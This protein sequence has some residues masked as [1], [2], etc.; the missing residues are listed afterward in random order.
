MSFLTA[1]L[2]VRQ[3]TKT[4]LET[5]FELESQGVTALFG[6]SGAG[7]TT[8]LKALAGL[9]PNQYTQGSVIHS[10]Y[11]SWQTEQFLLAPEKR[12]IGLVFQ[13]Q[14]LFPHLTIGE[15]LRYAQ[16]RQHDG[17][18]LTFDEI[19]TIFG[20]GSLLAR[21]PQALSGG[22]SQRAALARALIN[23]PRLLLMDEPLAALDWTART[24]ILNALNHIKSELQLP[25][26]YVSHQWDEVI[27]LADQVQMMDK[28][29]ITRSD[30]LAAL[31]TDIDFITQEQRLASAILMTQVSGH[32]PDEG[33]TEL[34]LGDQTILVPMITLN[35]STNVRLLIRMLDVSLVVEPVARSSILNTLACRV[36]H[37]KDHEGAALILLS[38][39][40]QFF[41]ARITARS[42]RL[43]E[44]KVGQP[45]FAQIK[46][47]ALN[48]PGP[49]DG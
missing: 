5:P 34:K 46:A 39:E 27:Q 28:G 16:K 43:L 30:S 13:Q 7:K 25:M 22:E 49:Q 38:C 9:I 40:G 18:K 8:L 24:E 2:A 48:S 10:K 32:L 47:T 45:I 11:G 37:I 41:N 1:V 36:A 20:L 33:L 19:V 23:A 14:Q 29:K 17:P 12:G 31:T 44:L 4:L 6:P 21:Y 35:P 42:K 3:G 26:V 15:N